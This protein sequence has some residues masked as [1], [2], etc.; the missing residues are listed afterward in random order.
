RCDN[1]WVFCPDL[2]II[3]NEEYSV[4]YDYCKGCG[5]CARECPRYVIT[6]EEER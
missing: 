3:R 5:I 4:N 2:S 1:C 6:M